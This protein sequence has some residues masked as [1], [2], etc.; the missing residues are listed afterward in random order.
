MTYEGHSW[1]RARRQAGAAANPSD[2]HGSLSIAVI[3]P[4]YRVTEHVVDVIA[5]IGPEVHAIYC[6]D[7]G[8][9]DGSGKLIE[10]SISDKRVKVLYHQENEGVGAAMLTGYRQALAEGHDVL[11]K[12]D[13]DGQMDPALVPQFVYPIELGLA[14]YTKGNRFFYIENSKG[15]PLI[16]LVGNGALSFLTKLSSGYWNIF[17]PTNGY[18]AMHRSVGKLI[19]GRKID[20]RY[21]FETD[22]LLNLYLMRAVVQDVPMAAVYGKEKSH[23]KV[24]RI[25]FPF[26]VKNLKNGLR[27]FFIHYLIRDFSLATV[28]AIVALILLAFGL[29]TGTTFWLRSYFDGQAATAGQVMIA[30]LPILS[31]TQLLLSALNFDMRNVPTLPQQ[32][33][34]RRAEPRRHSGMP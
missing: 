23:L 4:C 30:A 19:V 29:I 16:R 11:V 1:A 6:V 5:Q 14:D 22:M 10:K 13:G 34:F 24:R 12:I 8:C 15:M 25:A 18:T 20:K 2:R 28:E 31:G 17:D 21:F 27:R 7:D 9:P 33:L 3:I 26:L 32:Q